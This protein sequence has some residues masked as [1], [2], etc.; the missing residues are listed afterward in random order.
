MSRS[1]SLGRNVNHDPKSKDFPAATA[2]VDKPVSWRHYGPILDQGNLGS[3]TGNAMAQAINT[4]PLH[5]KGERLLKEAD[6]VSLYSAATQLDNAPGQYPPTDTGSNGLSVAKAAYNRRLISKYT[7][8]FGLEHALGALQLGPFLFGTNWYQDMF[9][10][11]KQGFVHPGGEVVGGHEIVC[12]RDTGKHLQFL[13]SWGASWGLNGRF[14]L[15]YE[16]FAQ[17][18]SEDGDVTVPVR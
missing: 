7:H 18:L 3:C 11:D 10:P 17:L 15:S 12:V 16:D 13:N 8:A 1:Y 14:N 4:L 6:A 2:N 5:A 9:T